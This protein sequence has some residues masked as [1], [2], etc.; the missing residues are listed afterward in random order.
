MPNSPQP[1]RRVRTGLLRLWIWAWAILCFA[2]SFTGVGC[3]SSLAYQ[4]RYSKSG[5]ND[6]YQKHFTDDVKM[7][8]EG[9]DWDLWLAKR[10]LGRWNGARQ[11][12]PPIQ[13]EQ[14]NQRN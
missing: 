2:A 3:G 1:P 7:V 14:E 4:Y 10:S 8:W 9:L 11:S 13:R 5:V 12:R 6:S